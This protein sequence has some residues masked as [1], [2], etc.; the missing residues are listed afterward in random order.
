MRFFKTFTQSFHSA[1]MYQE[2]RGKPGHGLAY[3]F[4]L[5]LFTAFLYCVMY[6]SSFNQLH[7]ELFVGVDGKISVMDDVLSQIARQMPTMTFHNTVLI[8]EEPKARVIHL[9][10]NIMGQHAEGDAITIDTTGMTTYANMQ[11]PVLVTANEIVMKTDKETKIKTFKEMTKGNQ[12]SSDPVAIT[13]EFAKDVAKEIAAFARN[14]IRN[15][16]LIAG[17]LFL[18]FFVVFLYIARIFMMLF[19]ALGGLLI[20]NILRTKITFDGCM[21]LAAVSFTPVAIASVLIPW[22]TGGAIAGLWLLVCGF[23]MFTVALIASRH[24][25]PV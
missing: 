13:P 8:S 9:A 22:V 24:D 18:I 6:V 5:V 12:N 14:N 17:G 11:T 3:S 15:F 1:A 20:A 16:Y 7:R 2:L 4:L 19:L 10:A 25:L 21:R 23:I